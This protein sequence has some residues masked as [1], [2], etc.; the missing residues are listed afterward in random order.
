[1]VGTAEDCH[2]RRAELEAMLEEKFGIG[3][4]TLQTDHA[5]PPELL[6]VSGLD[7]ETTG[8]T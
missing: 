8:S 5:A 4:T 6:Q 7:E 3:H 1:M 2:A